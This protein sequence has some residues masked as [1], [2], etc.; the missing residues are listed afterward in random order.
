MWAEPATEHGRAFSSS[1]AHL[2]QHHV[3][4]VFHIRNEK[5]RISLLSSVWL[6]LI[7]KL[8]RDIKTSAQRTISHC[9]WKK[10]WQL[11]TVF[12]KTIP[13]CFIFLVLGDRCC[14]NCSILISFS[15]FYS[16]SDKEQSRPLQ[17]LFTKRGPYLPASSGELLHWLLSTQVLSKEAFLNAIF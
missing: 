5:K 12:I 14:K 8:S 7:S 17:L 13:W 2:D 11:I 9:Q 6:F 4:M 10:T 3:W 15:F 16:T 1:P